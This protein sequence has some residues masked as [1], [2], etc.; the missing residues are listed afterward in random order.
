MSRCYIAACWGADRRFLHPSG[1]LCNQ[2]L[3]FPIKRGDLLL[4][5]HVAPSEA[6]K[7]QLSSRSRIN[8]LTDPEARRHLNE[9]GQAKAGKMLA[10][11]S[12]PSRAS[13]RGVLG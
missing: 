13:S 12:R 2:D 11:V 7:G 8:Q 4:E 10:K 5:R 1:R 6:S 9:L 3:E